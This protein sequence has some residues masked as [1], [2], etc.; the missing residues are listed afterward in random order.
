MYKWI[1]PIIID[2]L[3]SIFPM[4]WRCRKAAILVSPTEAKTEILCPTQLF[5]SYGHIV[6]ARI[7]Q[8][9]MTNRSKGVS[10]IR[11][12]QRSEADL[13]IVNLNGFVPTGSP[14]PITV[15]FTNSRSNLNT[16]PSQV[17]PMA[18]DTNLGM[19]LSEQEL[20]WQEQASNALRKHDWNCR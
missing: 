3:L 10:F 7:L 16:T 17:R 15:N 1:F 18:V 11:I 2:E 13:V 4:K 14:E 9:P 12:D 20:Q 5:Q 8:D 19:N 6:T